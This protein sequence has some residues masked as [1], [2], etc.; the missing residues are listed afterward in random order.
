[1]FLNVPCQLQASTVTAK[2]ASST[3]VSSAIASARDGDTVAV[4]A[5]TA[6]WASTLTITKGIT[7]QGAGNGATVFL[8]DIPR[9]EH[10]Q[11]KKQSERHEPRQQQQHQSN[12]PSV[13]RFAPLHDQASGGMG[14][15]RAILIATLTPKQSFRMTGITFRYGSI[16]NKNS[17]G[18]IRLNGTC[19][20]IRIDHC[21]FDQLYGTHLVLTGWLYGVIDHCIFDARP[22]S[23]EILNVF[24]ANWGGGSN[25]F[26]DGSWA[27]PSYFGSEKFI[28]IEDCVFNN[29]GGRKTTNGAID[30][31]SGGRYVCRYNTFNNTRP[32][33]HGTETSGR[34]RSAPFRRSRPATRRAL[35]TTQPCASWQVF[36]FES[37][38]R[39]D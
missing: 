14:Q 16:T 28:F 29:A 39:A 3:D 23:S 24:H 20:S 12:T 35:F 17:G 33:N 7:L 8:D 2:S 13:A 15:N 27:E 31:W 30:S 11:P 38:R 5:G 37:A 22:G 25:G 34:M 1:M 19:P 36:E 18:L 6:S 10:R 32:G 9:G 4:P 21:H 26:G